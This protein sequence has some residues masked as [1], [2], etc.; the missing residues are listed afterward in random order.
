MRLKRNVH[1]RKMS[2]NLEV[3]GMVLSEL[4]KELE[5]KKWNINKLSTR[6]KTTY[7]DC[8]LSKIYENIKNKNEENF[9]Q[10]LRRHIL[11]LY[12]DEVGS[13]FA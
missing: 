13:Y 2:L 10:N 5:R 3:K 8:E 6:A 11:T 12:D 9:I 7:D 4:Y 1:G